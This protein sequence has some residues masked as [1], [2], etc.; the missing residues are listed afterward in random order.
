[1]YKLGVMGKGISYS[2]SPQIHK[3]FAKQFGMNIDYQIY[4]IE[5]QPLNFVEDFFAKGGHG[6]NVTKPYKEIFTQNLV[7]GLESI[8]CIYDNGTKRTSTD[9]DGFINDLK[10]KKIDYTNMNIMVY[11]LGGASKSILNSIKTSGN[12]F[13]ANRTEA[14]TEEV[15]MKSQNFK[16][17]NGENLD[18][19]ISC[20]QKLDLNTTKHFEHLNLSQ[21]TLLYDINYSNQTNKAFSNLSIVSKNNFY[22]GIGMLVEQASECFKLWFNKTP[23]VEEIKNK[24]NE[25]L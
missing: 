21:N 13:V 2:L 9:G 4:D 24:L 6:L 11:G 8:N 12:L 7:S 1:M 22:N 5:D 25:R 15:I 18:L 14:K 16:K 23:E 20:A 3:E 19:V 17:Y 10:S